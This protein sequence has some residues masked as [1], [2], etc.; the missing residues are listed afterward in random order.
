[1]GPVRQ[2]DGTLGQ[3][4]ARRH[5]RRVGHRTGLAGG[6]GGDAPVSQVR[7]ALSGGV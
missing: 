2:V 3:D 7:H 4:A 5:H 1:M 6:V